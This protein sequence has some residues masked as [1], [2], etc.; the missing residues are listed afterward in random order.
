MKKILFSIC[1]ILSLAT[2]LSSQDLAADMQWRVQ[3]TDTLPAW[4]MSPMNPYVELGVSEPG[5][6]L[7]RARSQSVAH[8]AF[9]HMLHDGLD[10]RCVEEIFSDV[11]AGIEGRTEIRR[12]VRAEI[13]YP[14]RYQVLDEHVSVF[15]EIFRR[16]EIIPDTTSACRIQGNVEL[17]FTYKFNGSTGWSSY[18][19]LDLNVTGLDSV[20]H[21]ALKTHRVQ[22]QIEYHSWLD[23]IPFDRDSHYCTYADCGDTLAFE[24]TPMRRLV[25]GFFPA[26]IIPCLDGF[27]YSESGVSTIKSLTENYRGDMKNINRN[28]SEKLRIKIDTEVRSI[29]DNYLN[30]H[31]RLWRQ[32]AA[33]GTTYLHDTHDTYPENE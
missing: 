4:V 22:D 11:T 23:G 7:T 6:S 15:G 1:F 20:S 9:C 26:Y 19:D 32:P 21:I 27:F 29:A 10:A 2:R 5:L 30:I 18:Y 16:V 13:D 3:G 12:L 25:K 14:F 31:S 28:I 8:A 17:F 24:H 33:D